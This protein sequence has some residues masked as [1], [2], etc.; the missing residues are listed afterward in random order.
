M[1]R[2]AL[3]SQVDGAVVCLAALVEE[4]GEPREELFAVSDYVY[5][6]KVIVYTSSLL[7]CPFDISA[8]RELDQIG[9]VACRKVRCRC[10]GGLSRPHVGDFLLILRPRK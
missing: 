6:L 2:T 7:R 4:R 1:G 8:D 5:D 10:G 3:L 9:I